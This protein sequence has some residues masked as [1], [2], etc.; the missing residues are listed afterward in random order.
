MKSATQIVTANKAR[1]LTVHLNNI[2]CNTGAALRSRH[3]AQLNYGG[4]ELV[5]L[6]KSKCSRKLRRDCERED[7]GQRFKQ[8]TRQE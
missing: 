6:D 1:E 3:F 7:K 8:Q 4:L 5:G 2:S